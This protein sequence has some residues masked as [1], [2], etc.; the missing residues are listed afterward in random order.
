VIVPDVPLLGAAAAAL[1][2]A[3]RADGRSTAV[4][5]ERRRATAS[6]AGGRSFDPKALLSPRRRHEYE[7]L[8]RRL[9]Q[10]GIVSIDCVSAPDAVMAGFEEF[11]ALEAAGWKGQLGTALAS[12]PA[13]AAFARNAVAASAAR[14]AVRI[15]LLRVNARVIA[16]LV[17]F[18]A[19]HTAYTWKIAYDENYGR[20]S[21]GAQV[22]LAASR[23]LLAEPAVDRLDSCAGPN[24]SLADPLLPDRTAMGT[25]VISPA[26]AGVSYR[27]GLAAARAEAALIDAARRVRG[28]WR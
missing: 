17:S 2:N 28:L 5:R 7:R 21:P 25:L 12:V 20:F 13:R 4:M 11:L 3:S 6:A 24:H 1:A 26:R 9:H 10:S 8:M 18:M 16:G 15:H 27:A 19:G 14:G 22:M 23:N